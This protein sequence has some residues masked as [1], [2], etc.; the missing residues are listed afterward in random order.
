MLRAKRSGLQ[1]F[2][3][4][5]LKCL[6][7]SGF[8]CASLLLLPLLWTVFTAQW[9]DGDR[10]LLRSIKTKPRPI[11]CGIGTVLQ[12][13]ECVQCPRDRFSLAGWVVCQPLLDCEDIRHT[14][15]RGKL[16][17]SLVHWQYYRAEWSG[18]QVIYGTFNTLALSSVNYD[19]IG[20]FRRAP[21]VLYPIGSCEETNTVLFASNSTFVEVGNHFRIFLTHYPRC[22]TC[23]KRL[24]MAIDYANVLTQL[25]GVNMTLCNSRTLSHVL[26]QFVITDRCGLVLSALDNL[27][28]DTHGPI[29]CHPRELRGTFV[30]PEQLWPHGATK[31]FNLDEQPKYN[32]TSD[33]WKVPEVIS[34]FLTPDCVQVLDYMQAVHLR[35]KHKV[36]RKRPTA[37]KLLQEYE[38]ILQLL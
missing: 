15:T 25:H 9:S 37:R 17:V 16:L 35:C 18:Y 24:Q 32:R 11:S 6:L 14:T 38:Q 22:N 30:A 2:S 26:S 21:N 8:L 33:I 5:S 3:C 34:S 29:R 1:V 10:E 23:Q 20:L 28:Q 4:F 13:G 7:L 36:P 31:I 12:G 27:P 19:T